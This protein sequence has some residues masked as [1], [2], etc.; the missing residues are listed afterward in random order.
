MA[1]IESGVHCGMIQFYPTLADDAIE[2]TEMLGVPCTVNMKENKVTLHRKRGDETH[3][4]HK[5]EHSQVF[6]ESF[7]M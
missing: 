6:F 2:E 4:I 5:V 7:K 3:N 1:L